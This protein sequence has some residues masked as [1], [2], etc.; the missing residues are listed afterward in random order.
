MNIISGI[1]TGILIG[2]FNSYLLYLS[3]RKSLTLE[4]SKAKKFIII[5]YLLRFVL[6]AAAL[7]ITARLSN[8]NFFIGVAISLFVVTLISPY[9]LFLKNKKT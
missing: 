4:S 1:V 2:I 8:I 5:S 3:V 9:K 6:L 7:I